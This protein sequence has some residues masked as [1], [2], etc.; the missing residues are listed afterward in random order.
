MVGEADAGKPEH[1]EYQDN[2]SDDHEN[3]EPRAQPSDVHG[4]RLSGACPR[5]GSLAAHG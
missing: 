5:R 4:D 2:E 1:Y 3:R